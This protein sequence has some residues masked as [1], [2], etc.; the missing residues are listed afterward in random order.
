NQVWRRRRCISC[1][2]T[3]TT[4]ELVDLSTSIAVQHSSRKLTPFNRDILLISVY[5]SCKHRQTAIGDA[6]ALTQTIVSHLRNQLKDGVVTRNAIVE[7]TL[8]ILDRFD[9]TAT[10]V[11]KAYHPLTADVVKHK[12]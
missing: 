9:K 7:A 1:N 5:E 10:T 2:N 12:Q 6:A 11:Y 8:V 4:H 3:F